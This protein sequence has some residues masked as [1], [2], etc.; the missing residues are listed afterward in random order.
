MMQSIL[1]TEGRDRVLRRAWAADARWRLAQARLA[2]LVGDRA[3]AAA[4][5]ASA[6]N[7]RR[8][9]ARFRRHVRTWPR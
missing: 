5:L 6:G 3:F 1:T 8:T 4:L 9:A 2:R 7:M